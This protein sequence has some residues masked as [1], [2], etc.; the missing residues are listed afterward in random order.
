[1]VVVPRPA[2]PSSVVVALIPFYQKCFVPTFPPSLDLR[3]DDGYYA[4]LEEATTG[5][6]ETWFGEG[7][8]EVDDDSS[9]FLSC[10]SEDKR[11]FPALAIANAVG[12]R[13]AHLKEPLVSFAEQLLGAH[14]GDLSKL[15]CA[16]RSRISVLPRLLDTYD[17][18]VAELRS[19]T[20][21][22]VRHICFSIGSEQEPLLTPFL[23]TLDEMSQ[24]LAEREDMSCPVDQALFFE[25]QLQ[26][27]GGDASS[28]GADEDESDEVGSLLVEQ[29]M[30]RSLGFQFP[31][32]AHH[33]FH[34]SSLKQSSILEVNLHSI[35]SVDELP[36]PKNWTWGSN[37]K[38]WE[39]VKNEDPMSVN[40]SNVMNYDR[41][42]HNDNTFLSHFIELQAVKLSTA[43]SVLLSELWHLTEQDA[44]VA[45]EP[46]VSTDEAE[47]LPE[48]IPSLAEI[49]PPAAAIER[50]RRLEGQ[51]VV[52]PTESTIGELPQSKIAQILQETLVERSQK[53]LAVAEET[54]QEDGS[55][56]EAEAVADPEIGNVI[57]TGDKDE[58]SSPSSSENNSPAEGG[59]PAALTYIEYARKKQYTRQG[60][61]MCVTL[62]DH[63]LIDNYESPSS[64]SAGTPSTAPA[65]RCRWLRYPEA[66]RVPLTVL[67]PATTTVS[68]IGLRTSE[69]GRLFTGVQHLARND[70]YFKGLLAEY[71]QEHRKWRAGDES[72]TF[73]KGAVVVVCYGVPM[74]GGHG[75]RLH[76]ILSLFLFALVTKRGFLIDIRHPHPLI[77]VLF[78]SFLDWRVRVEDLPLNNRVQLVDLP[79]NEVDRTLRGLRRSP[80]TVLVGTNLRFHSLMAEWLDQ[81]RGYFALPPGWVSQVWNLLFKPSPSV[82]EPLRRYGARK[83][84]LALHFR[85]GNETQHSFVDP[86]R[87]SLQLVDSFLKCAEKVSQELGLG[88]TSLSEEVDS[89]SD[90][91][92]GPILDPST[93]WFFSGD[94]DLF[95]KH[96][97]VKTL[98]ESGKAR[99]FVESAPNAADHTDIIHVDRTQGVGMQAYER[100]WS[101]YIGLSRATAL[102][103]SN[104]F[105]GETAAEIGNVPF[106]YY[107][108]G[109]IPVDL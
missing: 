13:E 28:S 108:E 97:S 69:E 52:F 102:I 62:F 16:V 27:Q 71:V 72:S 12:Y 11:R 34:W 100:S 18:G 48:E 92:G 30:K 31:P 99:S 29:G 83:P 35:A 19:L 81:E 85:A 36:L 104:S 40:N 109:C 90:L 94:S 59:L 3:H 89:S 50:R 74:C 107:G 42:G 68:S 70:E 5:G 87:H 39:E 4:S 84:F 63:G 103:I 77:S 58:R 67:E 53:G 47:S 38:I 55:E 106:V 43:L 32:P 37:H 23:T 2:A 1:M 91:A 54:S 6:L 25:I 101:E 49:R 60:P 105:F 24:I 75:D 51:V 66:S 76:G 57:S 26:L 15:P 20:K 17:R 79:E 22:I 14:D 65:A 95:W 46:A 93:P 88:L 86:A 44:S 21:Q 98:V 64:T 45:E 10:C 82:L 7:Y 9:R 80:E 8:E 96:D 73:L 78:P 56:K 41:Y 61:D 33:A